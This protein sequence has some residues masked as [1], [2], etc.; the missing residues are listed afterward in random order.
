MTND[1]LYALKES[2]GITAEL[3]SCHT[4]EIGGYIIEGHVPADVIEELLVERPDIVG[5]ALPG[6]PPGSPGMGGVS[7]KPLEI[8]A[9]DQ[10]GQVWV[11]TNW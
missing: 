8:L 1:A 3:A 2:T 5:L 10:Q 4:A 6:M 9:F 11:Y 7:E